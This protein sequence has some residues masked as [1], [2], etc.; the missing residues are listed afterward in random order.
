[1][2]LVVKKNN[3][4]LNRLLAVMGAC[5]HFYLVLI[6]LTQPTYAQAI[7]QTSPQENT[8]ANKQAN[9]NSLKITWMISDSPPFHITQPK[10][11]FSHGICDLLVEKLIAASP[12]LKHKRVVLPQNRIHKKLASGE[13]VCFPCMIHRKKATAVAD[14]SIPT[15]L[16]PAFSVIV[17]KDRL[18]A[19]TQRYGASISIAKLLNDRRFTLGRSSARRYGPILQPILDDSWA[20]NHG[21]VTYSFEK[22]TLTTLNLLSKRRADYVIDYPTS[23]KYHEAEFNYKMQVLPIKELEN[24]YTLG[25]VGCSTTAPN[26]FANDALA[27]INQALEEHVLND[28]EYIMHLNFWMSDYIKN[29]TQQYIEKVVNYED[30]TP[31][32]DN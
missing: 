18:A 14:Y 9:T 7:T 17:A 15:T 31:R 16:Y 22:S 5:V 32:K 25:A 26:N 28:P 29:Y 13:P 8:Q 21:V 6:A 2:Q 20:Y 4:K 27:N 11:P 19:F 12:Y 30:S 23:H 10:P 24:T 1:M 3:T